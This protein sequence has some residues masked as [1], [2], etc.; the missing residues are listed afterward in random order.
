MQPLTRSSQ[1]SN[2]SI[3]RSRRSDYTIRSI[4]TKRLLVRILFVPASKVS[5]FT[6]TPF[7]FSVHAYISCTRN[8]ELIIIISKRQ[9]RDIALARLRI[10]LRANNNISISN[11]K[12][13]GFQFQFRV[14]ACIPPLCIPDVYVFIS[15]FARALFVHARKKITKT[16]Y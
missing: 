10:H 15:L 14:R 1:S 3:T 11:R 6:Q 7:S 12:I 13:P 2:R 9:L 4:S 8:A 16:L 5:S